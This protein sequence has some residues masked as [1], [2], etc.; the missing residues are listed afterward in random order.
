MRQPD[1]L[2]TYMHLL[3]QAGWEP[4][5]FRIAPSIELQIEPDSPPLPARILSVVQENETVLSLVVI[6]GLRLPSHLSLYQRYLDFTIE[7]RLALRA[8]HRLAPANFCIVASPYECFLYDTQTEEMLLSA[9]SPEE[10]GGRIFSLFE[11]QALANGS[12]DRLPR[13][14]A[15]QWGKDLG[16]W[17]TIWAGKLG[18]LS[19]I[20]PERLR[21]VLALWV[22]GWRDTLSLAPDRTPDGVGVIL[23]PASNPVIAIARHPNSADFYQRHMVGIVERFPFGIFKAFEP[24]TQQFWTDESITPVVNS[25][26]AEA[27]L[28]SRSKFLSHNALYAFTNATTEKKSWRKAITEDV[29][30]SA[31]LRRKDLIIQEPIVT[32]IG[33]AGYGWGIA[34]LEDILV[35]WLE[36][37]IKRKKHPA[38]GP[39][40]VQLDLFA[41]TPW[42]VNAQGELENILLFIVGHCFRIKTH[43]ADERFLASLLVALKLYDIAELYALPLGRF[44]PIDNIYDS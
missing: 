6:D 4:T 10:A 43:S 35:Y 23:E 31:S 38:K 39:G 19:R 8:A 17:I 26:L 30:I 14:N 29:R 7:G 32:D 18:R 33:E 2:Q 40:G 3:Q 13:R 24:L 36:E 42:G 9:T 16:H 44:D 1:S 41:P 34:L 27:R 25:F 15:Q 28:L 22:L 37:L 5:S 20:S 11:P 21:S 12:L